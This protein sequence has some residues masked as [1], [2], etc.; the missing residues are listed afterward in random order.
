M[1]FKVGDKVVRHPVLVRAT[2]KNPVVRGEPCTIHSIDEVGP[3]MI[4]TDSKGKISDGWLIGNFIP[5]IETTN[6]EDWL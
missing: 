5:F 3:W 2:G 1:K 6:L 4:L